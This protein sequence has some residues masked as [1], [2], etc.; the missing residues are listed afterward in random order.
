MDSMNAK[1][2]DCKSPIDQSRALRIARGA[3]VAPQEV[4]QLIAQHKQF[5]KMC[6]WRGPV[7]LLD[8]SPSSSPS[9]QQLCCP[10]VPLPPRCLVQSAA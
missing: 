8:V 1:E 6:A 2:L 4:E 10:L 7:A 9:P 3:G 5:E